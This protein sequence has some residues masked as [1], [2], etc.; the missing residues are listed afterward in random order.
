[1]RLDLLPQLLG[2]DAQVGQIG[3]DVLGLGPREGAAGP[4][5]GDA[6]PFALV[7]G[8]P[9]DVALVAEHAADSGM[10]PAGAGL[11]AALALRTTV[12]GCRDAFLVEGGGDALERRAGRVHLEHAEHERRL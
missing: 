4:L 11:V 12:V 6:D 2:D 1:A 3:D 7:P 10:P 9:A 5:A 8:P